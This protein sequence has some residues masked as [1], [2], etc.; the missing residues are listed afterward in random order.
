MCTVV[1]GNVSGVIT[2]SSCSQLQATG[3]SGT[4]PGALLRRSGTG[5]VTWSGT[6]TTTF[7]YVISHPASQRRK[8]PD[9]DTE[10]TVRGAVTTN[11]PLGVGN[12]GVRGPV[13][14][15]LC[16][17][18]GLNVSLLAGRAFQL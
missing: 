5:T 14:A 16:V 1:S 7:V 12:V 9:S 3:G 15:K 6:G 18:P 8:C 2:I 13:R 11:S 10:T 4:F 17:N